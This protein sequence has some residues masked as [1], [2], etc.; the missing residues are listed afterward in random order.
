MTG[1]PFESADDVARAVPVIVAHLQ[2]GGLIAYPTETV[3]GLGCALLTRPLEALARMKQRGTAKPFL[4]L[5]LGASQAEGLTWTDAARALAHAFWPGPLTLALR[6]EPGAYPGIVMA[7]GKVAIRAT[8]HAG[9]RA[10]LSALSAP[11]TSTSA[12]APGRPPAMSA[13]EVRGVLE[14]LDARAGI[15]VLDGGSLPPSPP[16]TVLDCSVEP[17]RLLRAGAIPLERLCAVV[18][19]IDA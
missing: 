17:P 15:Q 2:A 16:S 5:V 19:E 10:I 8:S 11:L 1:I 3:Y 6:A 7:E 18:E 4:L 12:N 13:Q 14:A 9:A